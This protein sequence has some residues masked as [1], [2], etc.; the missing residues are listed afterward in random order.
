M[1]KNC[2]EQARADENSIG[3]IN[4][5]DEVLIDFDMSRLEFER[6]QFVKCKFERCN[7]SGSSFYRMG[8]TNCDFSNCIFTKAA[9]SVSRASSF[10]KTS[11]LPRLGFCTSRLIGGQHGLKL[12]PPAER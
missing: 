12:K 10:C 4:F 5:E 6:I 9:L 2:I 7:F 3:N 11:T 1:L 8:F